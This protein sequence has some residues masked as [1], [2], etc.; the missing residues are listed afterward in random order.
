[1]G[2]DW[3]QAPAIEGSVPTVG[4]L[5]H[6]GIDWGQAPAIEGSVPTVGCLFH[7]GG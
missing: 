1:M 7:H 3:G 6:H 2:I 4:C 5:F